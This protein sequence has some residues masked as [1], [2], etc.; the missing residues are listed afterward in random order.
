MNKVIKNVR[1]NEIKKA[2][3]NLILAVFFTIM[4]MGILSNGEDVIENIFSLLIVGGCEV[5]FYYEFLMSVILIINPLKSDLFKRYGSPEE[6]TNILDEIENTKEYEDKHL[7]I[8]QNYISDRKIY[9][10]II[11]CDDVLGVHKLVH[12]T[13]FV[14]DYYQIVI[15]DKYGF[16]I[17]YQYSVNEEEK[18]DKL[19]MMIAQKCKNA[20]IGYTKQEQE[21]IKEN[22]QELPNNIK[23]K[24]KY[25][26]IC[27]DCRKRII[28]GDKFCKECGCKLNW[29]EENEVIE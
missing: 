13:N 11:A 5:L 15:T 10:K 22:K 2:I 14:V 19:L 4:M 20:V 12:K 18:C 23:E 26:Y 24:I 21:H 9:S 25:E 6:I 8:S 3:A 17:T 16:E 28:Y 27:P 7:I 1:K 29:D